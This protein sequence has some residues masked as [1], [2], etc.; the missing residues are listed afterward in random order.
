M[1]FLQYVAE[2]LLGPPARKGG[3]AGESYW[4]CPFHADTSPSFHTMPSKV[5]FKDRYRCFGCG[6][7]GDEPDLMRGLMPPETW[8]QRRQRLDQW[9]QEYERE[10][11]AAR[12]APTG[13]AAKVFIAEETGRLQDHPLAV[14]AAWADLTEIERNAL[15]AARVVMNGLRHA[16]SFEALAQYCCDFVQWTVR[17]YHRH[18]QECTDAEC[19][20][21][22]CRAAR[23]VNTN[24]PR[25]RSR[26]GRL[27]ACR[28]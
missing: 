13:G 8:P 17:D 18:F 21:A 22:I 20:V 6:A 27:V 12:T 9:R 24:Q 10:V 15:L 4:C 5:D 1:T 7:Q 26:R 3:S 28:W 16:V 23:A 2:R 14:A 11:E 19:E 25:T